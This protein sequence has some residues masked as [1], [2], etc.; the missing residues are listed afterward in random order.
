MYFH[1]QITSFMSNLELEAKS[2]GQC[3]W[4]SQTETKSDELSD[5]VSSED[6]GHCLHLGEHS[7][8][9]STQGLGQVHHT[10]PPLALGHTE[11][12]KEAGSHLHV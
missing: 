2:K 12:L 1:V 10:R 5:T 4:P 6:S 8:A 11:V 7:C 3:P 9:Q